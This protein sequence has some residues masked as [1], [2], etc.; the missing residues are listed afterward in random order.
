MHTFTVTFKSSGGQLVTATDSA[1]AADHH[2]SEGYPGDRRGDVGIRLRAPSN[3]T[4]GL[5]FSLTITAIDAYGNPIL[6]YPGK[7]H[8]SGPSGIPLDYTFTAAD[9]GQHVFN[10]T[11]NASGTD[12]IVV[13]D[14]AN[15]SFKGSVVVFVKSSAS[16]GG[17]GGGG[18]GGKVV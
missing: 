1:N 10:V 14:T 9:A 4:V 18:G 6:G 2:D 8:F 11:F 16:G 3:V 12:T 7:V 13:Q 5:A 15:R 17:G